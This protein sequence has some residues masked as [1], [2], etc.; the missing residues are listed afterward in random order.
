MKDGEPCLRRANAGGD[1]GDTDVHIVRFSWRK[2]RET[3]R[4][5]PSVQLKLNSFIR[6]SERLEESETCCSRS[7]L[8]LENGKDPKVSS[9]NRVWIQNVSV[10]TFTTSPCVPAP[11]AHVSN[12]CA[13]GAGI[14][15]DVLNVH[16]EAFLKPNTGFSTCFSAC[17]NSHTHQTH[18]TTTNN[19][20]HLT[21]QHTTSH[22]D[23]D[24]ETE[25]ETEK[26]RQDKRREEK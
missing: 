24:R 5:F 16:T 8:K 15:G 10:C 22:G 4:L 14:H 18:T 20:T 1:C 23:R 13:R 25:R 19:D 17:R 9:V 2:G 26:E 3:N 21:T 7:I 12:T 6:E 11:R